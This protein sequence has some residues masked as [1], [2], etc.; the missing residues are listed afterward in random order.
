[1]SPGYKAVVVQDGFLRNRYGYE[2]RV[3]PGCF[4]IVDEHDNP[5]RTHDGFAVF[6]SLKEAAW[7]AELMRG[8]YFE[9]EASVKAAMRNLL[10]IPEPPDDEDG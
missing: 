10:D 3:A 9:G 6:A 4:T 8:A 1:M 5:I 7:C 2:Q